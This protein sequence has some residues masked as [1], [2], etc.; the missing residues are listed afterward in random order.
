MNARKILATI[1]AALSIGA[2][3]G[4]ARELAAAGS[5]VVTM[6]NGG[7]LPLIDGVTEQPSAPELA[8]LGA[9]IV[10][11]SGASALEALRSAGARAEARDRVDTGPRAFAPLGGLYA[12]LAWPSAAASPPDPLYQWHLSRV[13]VAEAERRGYTGLGVRVAVVD[14]GIGP[15]PDL[16]VTMG[17]DFTGS[18]TWADAAGH[19]THVAGIIAARS[20]NGIGGRG[21]APGAD[22]IAARVLDASGS[23]YAD[24]VA[25]GI[26]WATDRG[27]K[28]INLSLGSP[29]PSDIERAA[30]AYAV[31]HG[32]LVV[33]AAGNDGGTAPDYPATYNDC[34]SVAASDQSDR[35]AY[36][37]NRAAT[38]DI[39][40]P[41]VGI[42]SSCIDSGGYCEMSGTSMAAPV[43]SG[44]AA[45]V[46]S[47][48][49]RTPAGISWRLR[50]RAD[51]RAS[52]PGRRRVNVYQAVK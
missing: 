31:A 21:I 6:P 39:T 10:Y 5:Y 41:G 25:A 4:V 42:W 24:W 27:A 2:S 13:S 3:G 48:G 47:A 43:V 33:C 45:L 1:A 23:G 49:V 12:P 51:Y 32:A 34:L 35:L 52:L 19:G 17:A 7:A 36:W 26:V 20:G 11:V 37:S 8:A 40:A 16:R 14:S 44:A 9:H 28:V 15:H 46:F 30:L 18:G 22:L 50:S 29:E 38:V